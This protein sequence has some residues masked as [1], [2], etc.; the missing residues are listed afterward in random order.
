MIQRSQSIW[1]LLASACAFLS[2]K[3]PFF[4]INSIVPGL[5]TEEYNATHNVLLLVLTSILGALL[6]FLIFMYKN[7]KLQ[8]RL[9]FL[10]LITGALN[11][12]L[13]FQYGY[14]NE[15]I[16]PGIALSSA[17]AFLIPVFCIMAI[18][19]IRRDIKLIRS[20]DR[21]R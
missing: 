11:I 18:A 5:A 21:I 6:L 7:R 8:M 9:T 1:L 2:I 14:L 16:K 4:Y 17:F 15:A 20:L 3:F 13:Y 12:Y 10:A 19:G